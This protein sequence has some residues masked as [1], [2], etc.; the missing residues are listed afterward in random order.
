MSPEMK[1]LHCRV[2][3]Q[4]NKHAHSFM[5]LS[6]FPPRVVGGWGW[7]RGV[8]GILSTLTEGWDLRHLRLNF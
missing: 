8:A 6:M 1:P 4:S 2:S 3:N 7:E 5:Y